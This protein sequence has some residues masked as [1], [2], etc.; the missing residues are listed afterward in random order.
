[1]ILGLICG[2]C[3]IE[4]ILEALSHDS[5]FWFCAYAGTGLF[6][7]QMIFSF[8]G[9]DSELDDGAADFKF[10]WMS[11]HAFTGFLM[12]FGWV[13]LTCKQEFGLQGL[14]ST[15]AAVMGGSAAMLCSGYLFKASKKLKST[16]TVFRI[17]DCVGKDAV[18]YQ[19][20]PKNGAGKITIAI[21][22]IGHEVDAV[23]VD[24]EEI[25]SF[26]SVHVVKKIDS[27]TVAVTAFRR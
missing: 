8:L 12:M 2:G 5:L 24:G 13:G 18:V 23:S 4:A 15:A 19:R 6:V 14:T 22:H 25:E 1:M 7:L 21:D 10:K 20:I 11:K 17:E 16:G 9:T 26:C 27:Q 3:M